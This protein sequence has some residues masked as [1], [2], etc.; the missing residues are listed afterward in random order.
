MD[1]AGRIENLYRDFKTGRWNILL[2]LDSYPAEE[3]ND[4]LE[5]SID[6]KLNKH[7]RKR[8]LD[9]NAYFYVLVNK[10]AQ[11][12]HISD[13]EVHDRLLAQ[14]LAYVIKDGA[15]DWIVADWKSDENRLVKLS[16]KEKGKNQFK[17]YY[18]SL[19]DVVLNKTSGT[20]YVDKAGEPKKSRIFWHIKGSHEMD[21]KEMARLIDSTIVEAKEL[22]IETLTCEELERM[23]ASWK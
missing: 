16:V 2:S 3:I 20:P 8:S 10:I 19:Q 5:C 22:G 4:L 23:K 1:L 12:E 13:T 9:A 15:V 11:M 6:I 18:D 17:Y 14:N 7:H 21:S